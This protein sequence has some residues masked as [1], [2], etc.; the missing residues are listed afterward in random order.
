[1]NLSLLALGVYAV[2]ISLQWQ[3]MSSLGP[4]AAFFP[5]IVGGLMIAAAALSIAVD[6]VR[7][8]YRIERR[9]IG[10]LTSGG[11]VVTTVMAILLF[12]LLAPRAGF[13]L[14]TAL[15]V[16]L[17]YL[18]YVFVEKPNQRLVPLLG[19]GV[20]LAVVASTLSIVMLELLRVRL[21]A[22]A[23]DTFI[24]GLLLG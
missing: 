8:R 4:G 17:G 16:L 14:A 15:L 2:V 7:S 21:P 22:S 11:R 12:A 19:K 10:D 24:S 6:G 13:M 20:A 23:V 18:Q 1:M 9:P 5:R 3:F